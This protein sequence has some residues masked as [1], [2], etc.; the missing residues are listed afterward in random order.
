MNTHTL[1]HI[2][3]ESW[4]WPFLRLSRAKMMTQ[5]ASAHS[6]PAGSS[7]RNCFTCA[8][9]KHCQ[10]GASFMRSME[11]SRISWEEQGI[12][13][14]SWVSV[15]LL[16]FTSSLSLGSQLDQISESQFL[17]LNMEGYNTHPM[18]IIRIKWNFHMWMLVINSKTQ[19]VHFD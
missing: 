1:F 8:S 17:H 7:D 10:S 15:P 19:N 13:I 6:L 3:W 12:W 11:G 18:V 9:F 4:Y 2:V 5:A 14:Q 16:P